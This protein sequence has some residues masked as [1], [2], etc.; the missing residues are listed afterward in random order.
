MQSPPGV[1]VNSELGAEGIRRTVVVLPFQVG[2][3]RVRWMSMKRILV[4]L[5]LGLRFRSSSV[6]K[7]RPKGPQ[8]L[9]LFTV[10]TPCSDYTFPIPIRPTI[11]TSPATFWCYLCSHYLPP[12]ISAPF[13]LVY[14]IYSLRCGYVPDIPRDPWPAGSRNVT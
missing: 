12:R 9:T 6:I 8:D 11:S 2:A 13:V 1:T 14:V 5:G 7:I 4:G 3:L 10:T